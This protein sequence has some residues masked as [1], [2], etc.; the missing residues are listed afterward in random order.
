MR[1]SL[2]CCVLL[3]GIGLGACAVP[4]SSA[5]HVTLTGQLVDPLGRPMAGKLVEVTLPAEYG[6]ND[7]DLEHGS[8]ADYGHSVQTATVTTDALGS[9]AHAFQPVTYSERFWLLPPTGSIFAA[10]PQPKFVI[11]LLDDPAEFY[12]VALHDNDIVYAINRPNEQFMPG[13]QS[14]KTVDMNGR[15]RKDQRGRSRGWAADLRIMRI[16]PPSGAPGGSF[17]GAGRQLLQ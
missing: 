10:P 2:L 17:P 11:R 15:V 1:S 16:I 9:F 5:T 4:T 14:L 3:S 6:L 7:I 8:P 12:T 13:Q